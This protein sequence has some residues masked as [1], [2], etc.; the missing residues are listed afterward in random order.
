M[1]KF[2]GLILIVLSFA[3]AG[4]GG[5]NFVQFSPEAKDFHPSA[6]AIL[7]ATVGEFESSRDIVDT[8]VSRKMV[9][10]RLFENVID[11]ATIRGRIGTSTELA[12]DVGAY[13]QKINTLG[14]SDPAASAKLKESLGADAFFLTYVTSWGYGRMDG[15]KIARVGLGIKLVDASKGTI[16]FKANHE[17]VEEYWMLK[18]DLSKIAEK[19]V[20]M[21]LKEMPMEKTVRQK[22]LKDVDVTPRADVPTQAAAPNADPPR[23]EPVKQETRKA[24]TPQEAPTPETPAAAVPQ[25]KAPAPAVVAP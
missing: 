16:I 10:T 5:I 24:D 4:C 2:A 18:P 20:T 6:I 23:V 8:V 17:L 14:I 13:I 3:L 22:N 1:K 19:L 25:T 21:L 12:N 11:N 9:E 15:N 7:P